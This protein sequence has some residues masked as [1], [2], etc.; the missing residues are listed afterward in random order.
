MQFS[1]LYNCVIMDYKAKGTWDQKEINEYFRL[2]ILENHLAQLIVLMR[3]IT[4]VD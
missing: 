3:L 4:H 2:Q 1:H